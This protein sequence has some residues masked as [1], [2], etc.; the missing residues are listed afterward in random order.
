MHRIAL[1][2]VLIAS[3]LGR[4]AAA[5]NW[6]AWRGPLGNGI[7]QE[8]Q[9]PITFSPT[10]NVTWKTPLPQP[11]NSTPI[12]WDNRVFVT[13]PLDGGKIRS[14]MCF[15]RASGKEL[16]RHEVPYPD[17][18]T[19]HRDNTFCAGSPTTDGK[20]VYASFDSAGVVAC[21][22]SGKVVWSRNLSKLAHIFGP[23]ATPVLYKHLLIIHR[24]PGE[25]TH[26]VAL[27][28]QTGETVWDTPEV[29]KNHQLYGSWSTPVIYRAGDHD[30]FALSMPGELK[31]YDAL[32]GKELWRCEGLGPS[33]YPDTAIGDAVL[34]GVSGFNK[35]MMAVRMGGRGDITKTHRMW[36]VA[37]TQ[38]RIGSGV[39]RDG[40]LYVANAPG[41]AEC[42]EVASG[43][44]IWKERLGGDLWGSML[45]AG[46]R[47]YVSN[48]QG[49]IFVLAASPKFER[50]AENDMGEH[51]KAALTPSDGQLFIRTYENL[52][53]IGERR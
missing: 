44:T 28:K 27:D 7:C 31:G 20:L 14:L 36:H 37:E 50:I 40:H 12:V 52:Y 29:G 1:T 51:T 2:G 45:L 15:D 32:T 42:I 18:E 22:F 43:K 53:C 5:E 4:S 9:L 23:A 49:K 25:P 16:W 48:T 38:Q 47:L 6:P 19:I 11:C 41:I 34:I 3:C 17:A 39:V 24:G 33:N 13:C 8:T 46:D 21:D 35:S 30:E 10:E 26:I